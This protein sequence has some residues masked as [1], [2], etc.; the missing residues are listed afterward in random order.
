MSKRYGLASIARVSITTVT[1]VFASLTTA[2][3]FLTSTRERTRFEALHAYASPE[4]VEEKMIQF[5]K[6]NVEYEPLFRSLLMDE[7]TEANRILGDQNGAIIDPNDASPWTQLEPVPSGEDE[8]ILVSSFVD[9]MHKILLGIPVEDG[10]DMKSDQLFIEE[11][12]R[13]LC[14]GRFQVLPQGASEKELF[15]HCWSEIGELR[16]A[17]EAKTGSIILTPDYEGDLR[18][19]CNDNLSNP[20][21]WLGISEDYVEVTSMDGGK[22]GIRLIHKLGEVPTDSY[23]EPIPLF[24]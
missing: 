18:V 13:L 4:D 20:L 14:V 9:D 5:F 24:G 2:H 21:K 11:G 6:S 23:G 19:F 22:A 15:R 3:A 17:D 7:S 1:L 12:R 16:R 10:E 8:R